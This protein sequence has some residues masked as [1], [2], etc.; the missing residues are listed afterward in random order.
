MFYVIILYAIEKYSFNIGGLMIRFDEFKIW[1]DAHTDYTKETKSN[2]LSRLK[3]ANN[4]LPITSDPVYLFLLSQES[5]FCRLSVNVRSQLRRSVK[6]YTQYLE[7][8]EADN[9]E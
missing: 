7:S 3:G 2:L 8:E 5:E 6:M 9:N 4:I 1:L